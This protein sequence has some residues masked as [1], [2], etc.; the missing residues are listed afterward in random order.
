MSDDATQLEHPFRY[1]FAHEKRMGVL[2]LVAI[3]LLVAP[4]LILAGLFVVEL[5]LEA[6]RHPQPVE[7]VEPGA[8]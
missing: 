5:Y 4:M 1:R 7:M 2:P 6:A 3:A 8:R